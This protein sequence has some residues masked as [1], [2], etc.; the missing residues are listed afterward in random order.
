MFYK[1]FSDDQEMA[2]NQKI[3]L[4]DYLR[5]ERLVLVGTLATVWFFWTM[6]KIYIFMQKKLIRILA[7]TA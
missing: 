4:C 7:R 2:T 6:Y 5:T 3:G 1:I